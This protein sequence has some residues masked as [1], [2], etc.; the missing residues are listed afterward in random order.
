MAAWA[1]FTGPGMNLCSCLETAKRRTSTMFSSAAS[2]AI[3]RTSGITPAPTAVRVTVRQVLLISIPRPSRLH[4]FPTPYW[5]RRSAMT[6]ERVEHLWRGLR[7]GPIVEGEHDF[8][9]VE[10]QASRIGFQPHLQAAGRPH[11]QGAGN[12]ERLGR[13]SPRHWRKEKDPCAG[14]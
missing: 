9:I 3:A 7:G 8:T 4:W 13:A 11:L 10:H 1:R 12:A 14:Q 5:I 6:C 2:G